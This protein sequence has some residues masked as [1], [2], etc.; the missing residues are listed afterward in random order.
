MKISKTKHITKKGVVK[1]NPVNLYLQLNRQTQNEVDNF[2]M[3]FAFSEEQLKEGLKKLG[4]KKE[5]ALGIGGGGFIRKTDKDKYVAM[6]VKHAKKHNEM[7]KNKTYVYQ[8]FRYELANH[9][10]VCT[11]DYDDTLRSVGLT[12]EKVK[13]NPMWLA[14]LE[15]ARRDYMN[16]GVEC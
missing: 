1:K 6:I 10:F 14:Q 16:S 9:E 8:M 4:I 11:G 5:E 13:K 7:L 15:K 2:P 12:W 3:Q